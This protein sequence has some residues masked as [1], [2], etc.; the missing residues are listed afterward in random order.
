MKFMLCHLTKYHVCTYENKDRSTIV[1]KQGIL[2]LTKSVTETTGI[3]CSPQLWIKHFSKH[4][5]N[6]TFTI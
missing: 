2:K 5:F 3:N 1:F 4:L 6:A